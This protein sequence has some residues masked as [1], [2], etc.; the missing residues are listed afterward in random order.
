[1]ASF[2]NSTGVDVSIDI[3]ITSI[4]IM[5]KSKKT[6]QAAMA[7][8]TPMEVDRHVRRSARRTNRKSSYNEKSLHTAARRRA[9]K[10]AERA[11]AAR[12]ERTPVGK[13]TAAMQGHGL[14]ETMIDKKL[15][16][17]QKKRVEAT[18]RAIT[19]GNVRTLLAHGFSQ[20]GIKKNWMTTAAQRNV[21][22]E[23]FK[24]RSKAEQKK[25]KLKEEREKK[26]ITDLGAM[27]DS[28]AMGPHRRSHHHTKKHHHKRHKNTRK[29][30]GGGKK[31]GCMCS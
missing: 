18:Q 9:E 22:D 29:R 21:A 23:V 17:A 20:E 11:A 24:A 2:K 3:N 27:I 14:D 6:S 25:L 10:E 30:R 12:E 28:L 7:R 31:N 1:M 15:R 4:Y 8:P 19:R 16:Q 26:E 5:P 13:L